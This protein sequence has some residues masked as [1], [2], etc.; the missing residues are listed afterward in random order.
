[1]K[2]YIFV[3]VTAVLIL[4]AVPAMAKFDYDFGKP[5]ANNWYNQPIIIIV[6]PNYNWKEWDDFGKKDNKG[7][8]WIKFDL[9]DLHGPMWNGKKF[10]KPDKP[11]F[12]IIPIGPV[13]DGKGGPCFGN[14]CEK[15]KIVDKTKSGCKIV[16]PPDNN[17]GSPIVP[18]PGAVLLSAIGVSLV[19]WLRRRRTL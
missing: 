3:C 13:K 11:M 9:D 14:G 19:G 17:G 6:I 15:P 12:P 10:G 4:S 5:S 7:K 18:A 1:M 16:C 8:N 2:K